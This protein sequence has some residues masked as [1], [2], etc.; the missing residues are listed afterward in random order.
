MRSVLVAFLAGAVAVALGVAAVRLTSPARHAS[1][2]AILPPPAANLAGTAASHNRLAI[3]MADA[4]NWTAA[5]AHAKA[6]VC[7]DPA[8]SAYLDTL[9]Y[10]LRKGSGQ[11]RAAE[12]PTADPAT[13]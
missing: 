13:R 9:A 2:A 5:V 1:T 4:G 8:N 12:A 7:S 10:V 6:A 11:D 3:E